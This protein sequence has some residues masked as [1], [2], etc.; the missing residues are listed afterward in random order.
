M[1]DKLKP[2]PFCG[3]NNV[4]VDCLDYKSD[5]DSWVDCLHCDARGPSSYGNENKDIS[6]KNAIE[7]WNK[8]EG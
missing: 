7:L 4:N 2:C 1:T 6:Y 8:R 5:Y 3:S